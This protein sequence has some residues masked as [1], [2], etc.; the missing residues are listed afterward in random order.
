MITRL[1]PGPG[2]EMRLGTP[3][4]HLAGGRAANPAN[5]VRWLYEIDLGPAGG[6]VDIRT[7][8]RLGPAAGGRLPVRL[9]VLTGITLVLTGGK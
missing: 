3:R 9:P 1:I 8:K 5:Q 7:E 4:G 6:W 2:T